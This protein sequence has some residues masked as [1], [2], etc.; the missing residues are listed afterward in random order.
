M[1]NVC[2]NCKKARATVHLTEIEPES[3]QPTEMHLCEN[4]ARESGSGPKPVVKPQSVAFSTLLAMQDA[5]KGTRRG[6]GAVRPVCPECG[7]NYQEFRVKG[8]FGCATC[9]EAF[10]EGLLPL[11]EKVHGAAQY[12]GPRP[13][14]VVDAGSVSA[15]RQELIDLRRRLNHVVRNEDYEEA[16]RLRDR[17]NEVEERLANAPESADGS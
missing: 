17:I 5:E 3:N 9:Y 4:C 11:L 6:S 12:V 1:N 16:A 13:R 14:A 2:Q 15:L 7:M 10:E 8:R